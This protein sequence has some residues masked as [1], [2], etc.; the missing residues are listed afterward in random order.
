LSI[1]K[2]LVEAHGGRIRVESEVGKGSA[3]F[4]FLP[5]G[6]ILKSPLPISDSIRN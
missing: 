6:G 4:I 5:L 2:H 1:T 3:F